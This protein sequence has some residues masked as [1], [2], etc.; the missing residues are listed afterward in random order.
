MYPIFQ[1][2]VTNIMNN[3]MEKK[4]NALSLLCRNTLDNLYRFLQQKWDR[5]NNCLE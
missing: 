2:K 3:I 1:G 5:Y 4:K